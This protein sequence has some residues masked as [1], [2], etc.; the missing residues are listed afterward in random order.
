MGDALTTILLLAKPAKLTSDALEREIRRVAG[1][2][3]QSLEFP[4]DG[5]EPVLF[6]LN[7]LQVAVLSLDAPAP[8]FSDYQ[9]DG[10]NLLWP[11][12]EADLARHKA[13]IMVGCPGVEGREGNIAH[14]SS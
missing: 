13:H 3:V 10:P 1:A 6:E 9:S 4:K 8:G 7:G 2:F 11:S 12:V 5:K 14:A